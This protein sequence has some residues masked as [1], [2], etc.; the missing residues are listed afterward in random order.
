VIG[1]AIVLSALSGLLLVHSL[2]PAASVALALG[3][4][5][6]LSRFVPVPSR[7]LLQTVSLGLLA[8]VA[9]IVGART[10]GRRL[11]ERRQIATLAAAAPTAPNVL[12]IVLD[13]VRS[14]N[15]SAY[16]YP[17]PT[18]PAL[19]AFA[20][21]G[22][23]FTHAISPAPWTRPA[24]ASIFTG[25]DPAR[26]SADWFHPLDDTYPTLAEVLR[27]AGYATAGF[28]GNV[29]FA[30]RTSGLD[31]GFVHF[32]DYPV[33]LD[34]VLRSPILTSSLVKWA[35]ALR[36]GEPDP[37]ERKWS[38]EISASFLA[39]LDHVGRHPFFAFLNLYDAH[40]PYGP[41]VSMAGF[42][43]P[44]GY[45]RSL[46]ARPDSSTPIDTGQVARAIAAYDASI[47]YLDA[48]LGRL[49]DS[50]R[51]RG[52]LDRTVVIVTSDHGEE[53]YEHGVPEHG[54]SLYIQSLAVPLVMVQSGHLPEQVTIDASVST[55]SIAATVAELAGIRGAPF[56]GPSL[57]TV[58]QDPGSPTEAE[59]L[60]SSVT[61]APR[62]PAWY[63]VSKG[64][65]RSVI[66]D[67]RHLIR[68]GDGVMELYDLSRDPGETADLVGT[69]PAALLHLLASRLDQREPG[70]GI[71]R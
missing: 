10:L 2:H 27:S 39:W 50:L 57:M 49:F 25:Q 19:E 48:S 66:E 7:R 24:H 8:A 32:E 42:E 34:A 71:G 11:L 16:G 17:R 26:L 28:V 67:G 43:N 14:S 36:G 18:T 58:L 12:L 3:L 52:V 41:P 44:G 9:V 5:F 35:E 59:P 51:T 37:A 4:G 47:R 13:A 65:M 60:F 64:D 23:R 40:T 68:R 21:R 6:Q 63:P 54:S 62:L 30:G 38:P 31:R 1:T 55:R 61:F 22:V 69:A 53:F 45:V 70:S 20:R 29:W 15:L 56:P 46:P 33:N